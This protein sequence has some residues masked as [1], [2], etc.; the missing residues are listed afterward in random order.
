[1]GKPADPIAAYT[2]LWSEVLAAARRHVDAGERSLSRVLRLTESEWRRLNSL[3]PAKGVAFGKEI[4]LPRAALFGACAA[5]RAR[6]LAAACR[7]DTSLIV[8][9]GSGWG[10]GL[11]DLYLG[12]GPRDAAYVGLEPTV[13]GRACA[14]LLASLEPALRF[15]AVPFDL[16]AP[17]Y[18]PLPHDNAHVLVFSSYAIET[19]PRLPVRAITGLF[20]LGTAVT[21]VHFEPIGWQVRDNTTGIGATRHYS[22]QSNHNRN[23]WSLLSRLESEGRIAIEA[24]EPDILHHKVANAATLVVW[25]RTHGPKD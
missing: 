24:C 1:M 11:F 17:D 13:T 25:R 21:G 20:R 3:E 8:E 14:E 4:A 12:G 16:R 7:S 15:R 22:L 2:Q 18:D 6:T 5:M 19:I 10:N 9:L 23:L